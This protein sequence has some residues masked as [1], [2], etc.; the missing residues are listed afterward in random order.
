M[1]RLTLA[2]TFC[3]FVLTQLAHANHGP[4][5]SGGGSATVSGE[6]LKP[7]HFELS[8]REDY[9]QFEHFS[10]GAVI[11]R[12]E[13]SGDF[14]VLD[15]GFLTSASLAVGITEDFQLGMSL[16]YFNGHEFRG[17][18][19]EDGEV[20]L[21]TAQP[22]GLTD[23]VLLGKYR[24][25]HGEFG[26]LA[27][28]GGVIFPTGRDDVA[29]AESGATL[30]PTEQPGTGR[31]GIPIGVGYSRFLTSHIT[32]DASAVYTYRFE[33]DGFKVGDRLD[34]GVAVA[35]RITDSIKTF[36]QFSVFGELNNV[37]LFADQEDGE[38]NPN[39]G[40]NVL[41]FTPGF[42]TRFNESAALTVAPSIPVSQDLVGEQGGVE[43][44]VAVE[45]TFSF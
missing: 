42:R 2:L 4:G 7:G 20:E 19:A 43:F 15:Y 13:R 30:E 9:T 21:D 45:L 18:E 25:M 16:G 26:N 3:T 44:K 35:Y 6:I 40:G 24:V 11:R 27:I 34:V 1:R 38:G 14:D 12:A 23:L 32:L 33:R 37:Y 29:L 17:A 41:Y 8:L 31:W 10:D 36:P 28:L 39:S 22:S 5:A